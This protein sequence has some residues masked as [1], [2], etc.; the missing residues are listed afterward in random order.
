MPAQVFVE[1]MK[2]AQVSRKGGSFEIVQKE[3]PAPGRGEV[4]IQ[5]KACGICH[6]DLVTKENLWP[7][8]VYPRSPGHEIAGIVDAVGEE[9]T[10]WKKGQRV[11]LGW[12]GRYCGECQSCR[13]GDFV[14]C[15]TLQ[16]PGIHFDGGY[17]DYVIAPSRN[18]APLPDALSFEEAAPI[19]CAGITTFNALRNSGAQPPALVAIQGIGGLGHLGIQFA[20]K[21]GFKVAAISRGKDKEALARKLGAHVYIDADQ[22]DPAGQLKSL[23]GAR[24]ILATAPSGKSMTPLFGGLGLRGVMITVGA[25]PDPI[26]VSSFQ[27]IT[28]TRRLQGWPS[29]NPADSEDALNFCAVTGVR[30]MIET[31][32]LEKVSEAFDRMM[33]NKV[34]FRAV[35]MH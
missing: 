32:P 31:F 33:S 4:R 23:G 10:V 2:A 20:S 7:G 15:V 21:M 28:Q 1:T 6:S 34:R 25:S 5:V 29:G 24:V 9:V 18:L 19:L 8:I 3:I 12:N 22:G 27:L 35:L 17:A 26:E 13:R 16:I 14:N 30:P 11:G